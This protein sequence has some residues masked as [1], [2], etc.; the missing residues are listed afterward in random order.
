[1]ALGNSA[2]ALLNEVISKM[3][4]EASV[5]SSLNEDDDILLAVRSPDSAILIGRKG[6]N[7]SAM[8]FLIN[9]IVLNDEE[10]ETV[11]RIIVDVEGYLGRRQESLEE[12]AFSMA[13]RAK[14]TGRTMRVRPLN[15]QERRIIHLCLE[16]SEG[17][18]TF[19]L[20]NGLQRRVVIVPDGAPIPTERDQSRRGPRSGGESRDRA[21]SY[22][23]SYQDDEY[24]Q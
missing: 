19:S 5:E 11:D 23:G 13:E 20:G 3:G 6:R 8:Q 17:V 24:D 15:P 10:S 12:M 1:M 16:D 7:L 21:E 2:G 9:R 22:R 4:I 18:K 14:E